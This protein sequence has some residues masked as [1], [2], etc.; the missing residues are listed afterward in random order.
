MALKWRHW[1]SLK[2]GRS[3]GQAAGLQIRYLRRSPR[4]YLPL[5]FG[6]G[7]SQS[8]CAFWTPPPHVLEQADHSLHSAQPPSTLPGWCPTT[9]H[10]PLKHHLSSPQLVPSTAPSNFEWQVIPTVH[11]NV[12]HTLSMSSQSSEP[13]PYWSRHWW[14]A[15]YRTP[16]SSEFRGSFSFSGKSS[17]HQPQPRS[18]KRVMY[19]RLQRDQ[20]GSEVPYRSCVPAHEPQ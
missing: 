16:G 12:L 15:L 5:C 3:G 11:H 9:T 13:D 10:S 18:R 14:A 6:T 7:L 20:R 1:V 4:Q 2:D 8:L 19:C 17:R